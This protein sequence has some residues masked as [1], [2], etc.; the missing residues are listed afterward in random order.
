[1]T[2][3]SKQKLRHRAATY[4]GHVPK[5][6]DQFARNVLEPVPL[7]DYHA[8][9]LDVTEVGGVE[10]DHLVGRDHR[11]H[12]VRAIDLVQLAEYIVNQVLVSKTG[13]SPRF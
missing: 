7:V 8:P 6:L 1:M 3:P 13:T 12:L 5:G 4:Q 10:D 11:L 2:T 9:P